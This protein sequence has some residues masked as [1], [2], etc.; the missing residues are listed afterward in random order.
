MKKIIYFIIIF[1]MSCKSTP[2]VKMSYDE[3][4]MMLDIKEKEIRKELT[5]SFNLYKT[6]TIYIDTCLTDKI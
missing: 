5:D 3:Y 1:L 2:D 6:D 4:N